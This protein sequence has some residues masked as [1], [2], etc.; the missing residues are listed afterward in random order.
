MDEELDPVEYLTDYLARQP[1][2]TWQFSQ[3]DEAIAKLL[4]WYEYAMD[5]ANPNPQPGEPQ[6]QEHLKIVQMNET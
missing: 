2:S 6:C 4:K 1:H 3:L 5:A